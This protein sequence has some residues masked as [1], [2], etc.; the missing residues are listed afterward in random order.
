MKTKAEH[1]KKRIRGKVSITLKNTQTGETKVV[2]E[3]L[4]VNN[5]YVQLARLLGNL[6]TNPVANI[7]FGIG[8]GTPPAPSDTGIT[9]AVVVLP[10]VVAYPY[11][12]TVK[13]T[14]TWDSAAVSGANINEV[15]LLFDDNSLA[16]RYVFG[17]MTKS[18]GWEW[19]VEWEFSYTV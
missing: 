11:A 17:V 13:F 19:A 9:G 8:G 6:V 14:A 7:A 4:V 12:Y 3:N 18:A 16:A 15:G 5:A 2:G 10:V 1:I